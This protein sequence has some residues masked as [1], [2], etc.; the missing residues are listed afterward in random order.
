LRAAGIEVRQRRKKKRMVDY[1]A[2]IPFEKRP[3]IGFHDTSEEAF[4]PDDIDFQHLRQQHL[5]GEL[6]S[7][8]EERER[9]KDK[10]K[11]KQR[12]E[13]DMPSAMLNNQ[14]WKQFLLLFCLWQPLKAFEEII[15]TI[16]LICYSIS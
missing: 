16:R 6:R 4:N 9:R 5:D 14:V 7:E 15:V 12:K 8:K 10:Q 3:A 13:N 11:L 1:N 2:E